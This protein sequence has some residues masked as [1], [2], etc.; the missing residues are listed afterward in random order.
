MEEEAKSRRMLETS[1]DRQTRQVSGSSLEPPE[2]TD[3][4]PHLDSSPEP[5]FRSLTS[6]A[7]SLK[8]CIL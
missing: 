6:R 3:L 1:G 8:F 2:G 4:C 7:G 5:H